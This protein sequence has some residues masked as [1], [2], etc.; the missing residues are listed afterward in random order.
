MRVASYRQADVP[1][2]VRNQVQRIED[3]AWPAFA[4]RVEPGHDPALDPTTVVL[5]DGEVVLAALSVLTKDLRHADRGYR[6]SGLSSVVTDP[7]RRGEGLG[8]RLVM[9]ARDLVR[10]RGDDLCLFTCDRELVGFYEGCGFTELPGTVLVGGTPEEPF[11]S[12]KVDKATMAAFFSRQAQQHAREF[13]H[14]RV[15]LYPGLRDRLWQVSAP[16]RGPREG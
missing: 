7:G 16:R 6:A 8:R 2:R 10:G 14:A 15:E 13:T 5:Q 12:D 3:V 11:P 4:G 1:T 9:A